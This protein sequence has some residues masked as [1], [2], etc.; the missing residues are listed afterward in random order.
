MEWLKKSEVEEFFAQ[1]Q[2]RRVADAAEHFKCSKS[3]IS[4]FCKANGIKVNR[5][6]PAE[7]GRKTSLERYGV[8]SPSKRSEVQ[9]KFRKTMLERYGVDVPAHSEQIIEKRRKTIA[10]KRDPE[11]VK[12]LQEGQK[13]CP[14]CTEVKELSQFYKSKEHWTGRASYCI[15]CYRRMYKIHGRTSEYRLT[16]RYGIT[17]AQLAAMLNAQ[18]NKCLICQG[19]LDRPHI[20]H[21]HQTGQIRGILC[22]WCNTGLGMFKDNPEFLESAIRYLQTSDI[23]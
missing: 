18:S 2:N 4:R 15:D 7:R 14:K 21:N 20:D 6:S 23:I 22:H 16:K 1:D 9:A 12:L 11:A 5:V 3:L 8:D 10:A 17:S 13:L 19:D